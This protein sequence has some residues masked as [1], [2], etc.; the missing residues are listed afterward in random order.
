MAGPLS[1][2]ALAGTEVSYSDQYRTRCHEIR[3]WNVAD[4]SDRRLASHCFAST[5]TGSGV[6]AV[7]AVGGRALWLTYIGGN[8]REWSLWTKGRGAGAKRI[9][10]LAADVDGPAPILVGHAW[11]SSL[12]YAIG[13]TVIVLA[14]NGSRRFT[15][16]APDRVVALTAHSRG[17]AAVLANGHVLTISPEGKVLREL[18]FE[19]G[20]AQA[21]VLAAPGLLVKTADGLEIR[22]GDA[23][24][25]I[26]LPRGARFLGYSEG[27]VAYGTGRQLRLRQVTGDRDWLLRTLAPGFQAELGRRGIAYASGRTLG[28]TAWALLGSAS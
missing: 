25:Q 16:T 15:L 7:A 14:P 23:I 13:R 22:K 19:P 4:K 6:A 27:I 20:F 11:E 2:V 21:A 5:S 3:L 24:R 26:S 1:A 8:I 17:Y 18:P 9:A 10:F 28:F 12:P